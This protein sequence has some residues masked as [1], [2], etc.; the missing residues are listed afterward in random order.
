MDLFNFSV[1]IKLDKLFVF[2]LGFR[3]CFVLHRN[4][5]YIFYTSY[6]I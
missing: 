2:S 6:D 1:S 3:K 5:L 4:L